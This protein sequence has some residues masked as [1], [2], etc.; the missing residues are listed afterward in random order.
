MI[1]S[2]AVLF[3]LYSLFAFSGFSYFCVSQNPFGLGMS[4]LQVSLVLL[5]LG[6]TG[7]VCFVCGWILE[8][9]KNL[10]K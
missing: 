10:E 5:F 8:L 7:F 6:V 2:M 3:L 9:G 4:D 1:V